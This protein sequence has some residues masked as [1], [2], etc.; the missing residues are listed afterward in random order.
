MLLT[1]WLNVAL[2]VCIVVATALAARVV[3]IL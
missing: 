1:P 3:Q 2:V